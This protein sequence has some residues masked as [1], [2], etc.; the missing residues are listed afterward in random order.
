MLFII[1]RFQNLQIEKYLISQ[2]F[3]GTNYP[4]IP[5]AQSDFLNENIWVE[6]CCFAF[7]FNSTIRNLDSF[8]RIHWPSFSCFSCVYH[9]WCEKKGA[10]KVLKFSHNFHTFLGTKLKKVWKNCEKSHQKPHPPFWEM[11]LLPKSCEKSVKKS[12]QK[13]HQKPH[14]NHTFQ[15]RTLWYTQ[16]RLL[17]RRPNVAWLTLLYVLTEKYSVVREEK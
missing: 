13:S 12:H 15:K 5:T 14:Q 7:H 10:K 11:V 6:F 1:L 16:D 2:K 3:N 8:Y 17:L 4:I 9:R